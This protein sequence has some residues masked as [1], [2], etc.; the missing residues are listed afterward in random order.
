MTQE[1]RPSA[2]E[3]ALFAQIINLPCKK[4]GY[5]AYD[6]AYRLGHRDARHAAAEL[7]TAS[8]SSRATEPDRNAALTLARQALINEYSLR[9]GY[10][11]RG[12]VSIVSMFDE[13]IAAIDALLATRTATKD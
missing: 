7:V 4:W 12:N 6:N 10:Q 9:L 13:A 1:V 11:T 3:P 8:I 5:E 2:T